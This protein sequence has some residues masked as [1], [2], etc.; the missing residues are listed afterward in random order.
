MQ[1]VREIILKGLYRKTIDFA[2]TDLRNLYLLY[3]KYAFY[4]QL[5]H[6]LSKINELNSYKSVLT[7][8]NSLVPPDGATITCGVCYYFKEN[9]RFINL[10]ISLWITSRIGNL[11]IQQLEDATNV[12]SMGMALLLMFEHELTHL[13]FC[14]W[15]E[16]GHYPGPHS[17]LFKC[18]HNSFF[19]DL[20]SDISAKNYDI[21]SI[22]EQPQSYP[23]LPDVYEKYTYNSNS[24]YAD[25]LFTLIFFAKSP[26][27]RD[28]I[29]TTNVTNVAYSNPA[30]VFTSPCTSDISENEFVDTIQHLQSQLFSDYMSLI[31]NESKECQDVRLLLS[32]CYVDVVKK[33]GKVAIWKMYSAPEIYDLIAFAFP[34]L[35]CS[36]YYN[37]INGVTK[38]AISAKSMFTFWEFMEPTKNNMKYITWNRI[39]AD[40]IVFRNGGFPAIVNY[41]SVDSEKIKVPFYKNNKQIMKT[42]TI[43]KS[44]AFGE[45][46]LDGKYEMIGAILLHGV[47]PG[48]SGGAH[49][50]AYIKVE[51]TT[52]ITNGA[53]SSVWT[54]YNDIGNVWKVTG[55]AHSKKDDIY[56]SL[57]SFPV[58]ILVEKDGVKPEMYFYAKINS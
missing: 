14:L 8:D 38:K 53:P 50:T 3:D 7:F 4:N 46:I 47:N 26:I 31:N 11:S 55:D 30:S 12:D 6:R 45:Y 36:G 13:I 18:V 19:N 58:D 35:Q 17:P 40:I 9:T 33:K 23:V 49:Y 56:N 52:I 22:I 28:A 1:K 2:R 57:G 44:Q 27:I 48:K 43:D 29:F 32:K 10:Q 51:N 5:S 21:V 24:C 54:E 42:E 20:S 37:T 34:Q 41:G 15:E 25:S 39:N 16:E